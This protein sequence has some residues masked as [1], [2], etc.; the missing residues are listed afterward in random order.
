MSINETFKQENDR[1]VVTTSYDNTSVLEA[2]KT[3]RNSANEHGRYKSNNGL[4]HVGRIHEGD[5]VRLR[6]MG[7]NLLSHDKDEVK[8][9]L[10][11]IQANEPYLLTMPGKPIARKKLVWQ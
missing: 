9:A 1:V 6:N 5:I 4:V 10:L 2:N 8:R 11:Y 3:Q 7:Y